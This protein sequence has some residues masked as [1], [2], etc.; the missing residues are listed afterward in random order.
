MFIRISPLA[1]TMQSDQKYGATYDFSRNFYPFNPTI[2]YELTADQTD[3]FTL[4][5]SL[6]KARSMQPPSLAF[7][8]TIESPTLKI[9]KAHCCTC[10]DMLTKR[11]LRSTEI[12]T[13]EGIDFS[14]RPKPLKPHVRKQI[15][16]FPRC[17]SCF[18]KVFSCETRKSQRSLVFSTPSSSHHREQRGGK[19][20]QIPRCCSFMKPI[21]RTVTMCCLWCNGFSFQ[22]SRAGGL[23]KERG[24]KKVPCIALCCLA[25]PFIRPSARNQLSLQPL[26][27]HCTSLSPLNA[28]TVIAFH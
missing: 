14:A 20:C 4:K 1:S 24:G 9:P 22:S 21:H 15:T 6:L 16:K 7:N 28:D 8:I 10:S 27:P 25:H 13:W 5:R 23:R 2:K 17:S 11:Y 18:S 12:N 19:L 26:S 3:E